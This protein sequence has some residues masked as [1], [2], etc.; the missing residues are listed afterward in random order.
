MVREIASEVDASPA[1]LAV[2]WILAQ[3]DDIVPIP[4]TDQRRYL[5]E[6]ARAALV[7]LTKDDLARIARAFPPEAV[8]G[9]R[10]ADYSRIDR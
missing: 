8:A 6:N 3:G 1:Q 7:E 5:E 2:A 9:A 10:L 4:G